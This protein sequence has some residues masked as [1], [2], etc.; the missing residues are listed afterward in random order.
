MNLVEVT[1]VSLSMAA[2]AMSVNATNGISEKNIN[3]LK[4]LFA[5]VVFGIMQFVMPMIGY[6]IGYSFQSQLEKYIPWI[7][8]TLL[9][10]LGIKSIYSFIKEMRRSKEE[11]VKEIKKVTIP[12]ILVEG[13]ATSIDALCIGFVYL[14]L[15]VSEALLVFGIIG[16]VTLVLSFICGFLGKFIGSILEKYA[17]LISGLIFIAVGIKILV[18]SFI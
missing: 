1:F 2:D 6:F 17:S 9:L 11:P 18:E 8:F 14:D 12:M 16:I 5:S 3:V 10:L 7:A 4:L 13:V 15:I